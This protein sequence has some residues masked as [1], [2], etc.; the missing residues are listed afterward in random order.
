MSGDITTVPESEW[1]QPPPGF[2]VTDDV[3]RAVAE[4]FLTVRSDGQAVYLTCNFDGDKPCDQSVLALAAH[5]GPYRVRLKDI[6]AALLSHLI[7]RHG[8][9][10]EAPNA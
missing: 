2:R 5:G 6:S 3:H 7:Q 8:W 4:Q 1:V 10:R 9:T